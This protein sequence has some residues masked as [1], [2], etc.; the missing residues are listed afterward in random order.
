MLYTR[1]TIIKKEGK[2]MAK[3]VKFNDDMS[4]RDIL[5]AVY[6]QSMH[7]TRVAIYLLNVY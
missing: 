7:Y 5:R 3:Q 6:M 1:F 2:S 4:E